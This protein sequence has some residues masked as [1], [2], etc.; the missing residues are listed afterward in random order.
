M[1]LYSRQEYK[2][3]AAETLKDK[4]ESN[5]P[6]CNITLQEEYILWKWKYWYIQHNKFPFVGS[7]KHLLVV[8]YFHKIYTKDISPEA[9][10]EFQKVEE[11]MFKF[12]D[13]DNYFSFIRERGEEKSIHHLHYHFLPGEMKC[14]PIIQMLE[15]QWI[16]SDL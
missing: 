3:I 4:G 9:W 12:Y 11:F 7:K 8:P 1:K 13:G 15:K 5:C 2:K 16:T 10:S 6:F 14:D